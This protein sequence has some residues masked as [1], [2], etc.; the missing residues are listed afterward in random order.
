MIYYY[1]GLPQFDFPSLDPLIYEFGSGKFD[2]GIIHGAIN[3]SN[4]NIEGFAKTH[5]LNAR[6]HFFDDI[7][8]LEIDIQIPKITGFGECDARG[9]LGGFRMGGKGKTIHYF[10]YQKILYHIYIAIIIYAAEKLQHNWKAS[11]DHGL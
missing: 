5:F 3:V 1:I 9:N 11:K 8:H 4:F 2:S 7:F 10:F 6:S